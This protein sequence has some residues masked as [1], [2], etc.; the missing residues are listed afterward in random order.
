M[1]SLG[2]D[3]TATFTNP[4]GLG[5]FK[6]NEAVITPGIF[7]NRN[8]VTFRDS[9]SRS[10][11]NTFNFGP[12]GVII[13]LT[14]KYNTRQSAAM[15][16]AITQTANF[17]NRYSYGS[18]NNFSSFSEQFAEEFGNS[19]YSISDIST[20]N[21]PLPY[22]VSPAFFS[23]LI[24][25]VTVNGQ[26]IIKA[27]PEYIL[28]QGQALRQQ[29]TRTTTG[30]MYEL[31][32]AYAH[33]FKD[34]WY[35]GAGL[36]VPFIY[37]NSKT[38]FTESDTSA[39]TNDFSSFTFQDNYTSMGVGFNAKLGVIYRPEEYFRIGFSFQTPTF[40]TLT[41]ERETE[42]TT[43]FASPADTFNYQSAEFSADQTGETMYQ[44]FS[45]WKAMLSASYVFREVENVKRQRAFISADVEYVNH[46]GTKFK[47]NNEEP[48]VAEKRYY[49][50]LTGV[51]KDQYKGTFN[52]R[53]GGELK[54]NTVMGRLGFAYYGNPYKNAPEKA[55]MIMLSGGL[56]YRHKGFFVD[57]T[58]VNNMRKDFEI[59][60]RLEDRANVYASNDLT[61]GQVVA[62]VG[63][64]F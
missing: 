55:N 14:D 15:S 29:L 2:G 13:A 41:D 59:P 61:R 34:K 21:S 3:I 37:L 49:K 22:T 1:G 16:F 42:V 31:A 33:N 36:G 44:Q 62:T 8:K 40:M 48:T 51:V 43:I 63:V 58:Y 27:A 26:T 38:T 39:T 17:N 10:D 30:G 6:T 47:S 23:H 28:D 20:S 52:F 12:S 25:T 57:L 35:F 11:K 64:K 54:F 24:D 45:P 5:F 9:L 50:A 56:G 4:A 53:V 32:G 60:Y 19:N 46:K 18:L 7:M